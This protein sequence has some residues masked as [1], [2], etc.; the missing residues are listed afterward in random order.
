MN[1]LTNVKIYR[2]WKAALHSK[3]SNIIRNSLMV[4][5]HWRGINR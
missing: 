1:Y 4:T 2:N 5:E 3:V